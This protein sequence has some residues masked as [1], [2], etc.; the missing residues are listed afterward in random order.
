MTNSL[1][2]LF[3]ICTEVTNRE[4]TIIRTI[5]SIR[6][7]EFRD[8]EYI[9]VDNK[10][11]DNSLKLISDYLDTHPE[12]KKKVTLKTN[13][14]RVNDIASWNA[15][16]REAVGRYI[17]VCEGDDWF[18][19]NHLSLMAEIIETHPDIGVIVSP[20]S[21]L[22]KSIYEKFKGVISSEDM[23]NYL[24]NFEFLPPPSEMIF[25]REMDQKPFFYDDDIFVY[26]G[27]YSLIDKLYDKGLKTIIAQTKTVHRG[28]KFNPTIKKYFHI[29]DS[30]FCLK[31]RWLNRYQPDS[32]KNA[33]R[34]LLQTTTQ[35]LAQEI[36]YFSIDKKIIKTFIKESMDLKYIPAFIFIKSVQKQI[37]IRIKSLLKKGLYIARTHL[38]S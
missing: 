23:S 22:S 6:H 3:S 12:F 24:I 35:I 2:P 19:S 27:E 37:I 36:V 13:H 14:T 26:A 15:P 28:T 4:A 7:Q 18:S 9:I 20:Q 10:S 34:K 11:S 25:L 30:Y 31:H 32:Y 21:K 1:V 33:R 29:Q 38:Q 17:V 5:E 16:L 8:F